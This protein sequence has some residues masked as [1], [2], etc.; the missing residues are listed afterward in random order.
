MEE[1]AAEGPVDDTMTASH[2]VAFMNETDNDAKSVNR[3]ISKQ[4]KPKED[5]AKSM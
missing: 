4:E 2:G 5:K 1:Q 3:R